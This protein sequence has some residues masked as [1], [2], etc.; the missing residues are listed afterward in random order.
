MTATRK[1]AAI[2]ELLFGP[3]LYGKIPDHI[4]NPNQGVARTNRNQID[5]AWISDLTY[6]RPGKSLVMYLYPGSKYRV[7]NITR[8]VFDRWRESSSKGKFFHK[9]IKDNYPITKI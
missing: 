4:T 3:Q 7:D 5:S 8:G 9:F 6:D 1:T 2:A